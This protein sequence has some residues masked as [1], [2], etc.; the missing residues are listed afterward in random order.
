[1]QAIGLTLD[2][3]RLGRAPAKVNGYH[4]VALLLA[5]VE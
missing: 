2:S 5:I 1:V 4:L 3:Y